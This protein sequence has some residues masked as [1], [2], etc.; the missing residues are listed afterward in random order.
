M[1][2]LA[3]SPERGTFQKEAYL[4][5]RLENNKPID[6][7]DAVAM[8]SFFDSMIDNKSSREQDPEWQKDNLEYDL[9]STAW[10]VEKCKQDHY[11]QNLYA[12]MCNMQWQKLDVMP[13]LTNQYWSCSWRSSGGIVADLQGH[14]DYMNWYCSGITGSDIDDEQY[15]EMTKDQQDLYIKSK[16]YVSEG[17]VTLEIKDDLKKL[18]WQPEEWT[19]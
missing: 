19:D 18:G 9:R 15:A 10:L 3:S 14:G 11:A 7:E 5:R 2:K 1:T 6:D 8:V 4:K 16:L 17:T 13:I 12:A